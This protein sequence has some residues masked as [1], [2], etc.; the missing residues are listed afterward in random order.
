MSKLWL[1]FV[2][3]CWSSWAVAQT[4]ESA[5]SVIRAQIQA[6]ADDDAE[7]AFSFAADTIQAQFGDAQRFV[8]MVRTQYPALYRPRQVLF[9]EPV[10][11]TPEQMF[12]ELALV[13]AQGQAW[14]AV[15]SLHTMA[16]AWRIDGVVLVRSRQQAI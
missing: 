10:V 14:R 12:Q 7:H 6:L 4:P 16:G 11:V 13:D 9:S 2:L 5:Q 1:F 3:M 8:R 15:Y